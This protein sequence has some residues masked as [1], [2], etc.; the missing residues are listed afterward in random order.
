MVIL[1]DR[2]PVAFCFKQFFSGEWRSETFL[3]SRAT[4]LGEPK[5]PGCDAFE[6]VEIWVL[7]EQDH[8]RIR[9]RDQ[10]K[11]D[12]SLLHECHLGAVRI[13]LASQQVTIWAMLD[14]STIA[15]A[16][17]VLRRRD[18]WTQ[19]QPGF[20]CHWHGSIFQ[21]WWDLQCR[22]LC[23]QYRFLTFLDSQRASWGRW[24]YQSRHRR[25]WEAIGTL[26]EY[27]REVVL[28]GRHHRVRVGE[29]SITWWELLWSW[30]SP[31][32]FEHCWRSRSF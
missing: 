8:W 5:N 14:H 21:D 2:D 30:K 26:G 17:G 25:S 11:C 6:M 15:S 13:V 7:L 27:G 19:S 23:F 20:Q 4:V 24:C 9:L 10:M 29:W 31:K 3:R 1:Y 12:L 16:P 32:K 22:R 28:A 18:L